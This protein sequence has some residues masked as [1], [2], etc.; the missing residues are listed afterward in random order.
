MRSASTF[1]G[2]TNRSPLRSP[3][4]YLKLFEL[5]RTRNRE[6]ALHDYHTVFLGALQ[7][8]QAHLSKSVRDT[9]ILEIGCGQRFGATL[10]FH[11]LGANITGIDYDVVNTSPSW[12]VIKALSRTNGFERAVR[13][14]VRHL[15]FDREYYALL[16]RELG[17]PLEFR[18]VDVRRMDARALAFHNSSVEYIFSNAVFEHIDDVEAA[19]RE[20]AR[21]LAPG[22]I[23][24]IAVHLFPS[25]SGGHHPEWVYPDERPSARVPPWDHLR[26]RLHFSHVYLNELR[27]ADF[28]AIFRKHLTILEVTAVYEGRHLLAKSI[29]RELATYSE[30]DL[31]KRSVTVVLR[32]EENPGGG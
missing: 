15:L 8:M 2:G 24:R 29:I 7:C 21:V 19:T 20:V 22:G 30:E 14:V 9:T 23:A 11:S 10:L 26:E 27:E 6:F 13:S 17:Q 3:R 28:L 25:L 31:L 16:E 5:Y 1:T 18:E 32:K 4:N 12:S